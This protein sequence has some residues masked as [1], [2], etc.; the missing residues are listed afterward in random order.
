MASQ[1]V[2]AETIT[3][4]QQRMIASISRSAVMILSSAF[5][6]RLASYYTAAELVL[7]LACMHTIL[8]S[9]RTVPGFN[10]SW[11]IMRDLVQFAAVHA[12]ATFV[13]GSDGGG[14]KEVVQQTAVLNLILLLIVLEAIP[15]A[16]A[17]QGWVLEDMESLTTSISYIFSDRISG[18]LSK[19]GIPLAGAGLA[20]CLGGHRKSDPLLYR[21]LAFVGI[22]TLSTLAFEAISGGELSLVWPLTLLYFIHE[23]SSKFDVDALFSYGLYNA[24]DAIYAS[25]TAARGIPASTVAIG[26]V[27]LSASFP[28]DPVWAGVCVLVFV[29]GVS[30]WFM[31]QVAFVSTDPVLAGLCVV[32]G[33]HF[34]SLV[35]ERHS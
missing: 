17:L 5:N 9:I 26:F 24:S 6:K 13:S 2:S 11:R 7:V 19:L 32:T 3:N 29:Q 4:M 23:L 33:V 22:N 1:T 34:V 8:N 30:N 16:G 35:V 10:A 27:F 21:T 14:R 15:G 12:L 25:L 20:L 18:L 31:Q 28:N